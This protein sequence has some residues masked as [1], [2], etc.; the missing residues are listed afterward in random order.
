[1]M[2][3]VTLRML[4]TK[5]EAVTCVHTRIVQVIVFIGKMDD[6]QYSGPH[7][8]SDSFTFWLHNNLKEGSRSR[9]SK[10]KAKKFEAS[11][12]ALAN[13]E[14]VEKFW[15]YFKHMPLPSTVF[16]NNLS[17]WGV[18]NDSGIEGF[19]VFRKGIQPTWEDPQNKRGGEFYFRYLSNNVQL[20]DYLWEEC[21]LAF[22]GETFDVDKNFI[23]GIR[24]VDKSFKISK[25]MYRFEVWFTDDTNEKLKEVTRS[26]FES[27][28]EEAILRYGKIS[29][30]H[31]F[32][33]FSNNNVPTKLPVEHRKHSY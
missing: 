12:K 14:T 26:R 16:F 15:F 21:V 5:A 33:K 8:L 3:V 10:R 31:G 30:E 29:C 17:E 13:F 7:A 1:M 25:V 22:I 19:S 23:C 9:R 28:G 18:H 20:F 4:R 32:D 2:V 6:A 24:I 11:I 27:I